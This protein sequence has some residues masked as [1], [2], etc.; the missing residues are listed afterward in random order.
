MAMVPGLALQKLT[1]REPTLEQLE[2]AIGVAAGGVHRRAARRGRR[3][4][5]PPRAHA[6]SRRSS[7]LRHRLTGTSHFPHVARAR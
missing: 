2:V 4:G 6:C 1:T 5:H 3:P 7:G